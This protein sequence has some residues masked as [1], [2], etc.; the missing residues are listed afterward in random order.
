[1]DSPHGK[2]GSGI[3][4]AGNPRGVGRSTMWWILGLVAI[5]V[6]IA[7]LFPPW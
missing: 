3:S 2:V 1:M 5:I 7:F 4:K 6:V